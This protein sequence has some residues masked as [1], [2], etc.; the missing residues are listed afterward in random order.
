MRILGRTISPIEL[1]F[2][3][4]V[5]A[6]DAAL[7]LPA[8]QKAR[9][10]VERSH[11]RDESKQVGQEAQSRSDALK[12]DKPNDKNPI[13]QSSNKRGPLELARERADRG[14]SSIATSTSDFSYSFR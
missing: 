5:I 10:S 14:E 1:L 2:I 12:R 11:V 9:A 7:L 8:V 6:I 4:T 3:I 13:D